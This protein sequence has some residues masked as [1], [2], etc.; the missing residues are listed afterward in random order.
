MINVKKK[1]TFEKNKVIILYKNILL[2][3]IFYKSVVVVVVK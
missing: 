2:H 3:N 1:R